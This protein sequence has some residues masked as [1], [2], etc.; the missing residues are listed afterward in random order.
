MTELKTG[1]RVRVTFEAEYV[2][3]S[4]T[5]AGG[6]F[7][8]GDN[9]RGIHISGHEGVS[10]EVVKPEVKEPKGFGALVE[11][12][13]LR[14]TRSDDGAVPWWG[15]NEDWHSWEDLQRLGDI[16]VIFDPDNPPNQ[17]KEPAPEAHP[18]LRDCEGDL[19]GWLDGPKGVGYYLDGN[20]ASFHYK[21]SR[22]NLAEAYGP[23]TEA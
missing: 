2:A 3:P 18:N 4:V 20:A 22:E 6:K 11:V 9:S 23:L 17:D 7:F 1:D 14:A 5:V 12:G 19:W 15:N 10:F 8:Y 13:G 16:T 21:A